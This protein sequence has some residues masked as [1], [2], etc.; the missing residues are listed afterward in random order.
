MGREK[1][2]TITVATT[3]IQIKPVSHPETNLGHNLN[4]VLFLPFTIDYARYNLLLP[5]S[6]SKL[7]DEA[8]SEIRLV[9]NDFPVPNDLDETVVDQTITPRV[10][11]IQ[12]GTTVR[13]YASIV[14]ISGALRK[15]PLVPDEF[16]LIGF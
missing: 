2:H 14:D 3:G 13:W 16:S 9:V 12:S 1:L 15:G 11:E 5:A 6:I 4:S 10:C 8:I 7:P